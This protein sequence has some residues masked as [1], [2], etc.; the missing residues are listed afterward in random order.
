MLC[1]RC[2]KRQAV[3]H[4][5][6]NINGNKQE[7]HLCKECARE[8]KGIF[9]DESFP[10]NALLASLLNM[11]AEAPF[12]VEKLETVKCDKCGQTFGEFKATGRLGCSHCFYVYRDRLVP[13]LKRI[14][15]NTQHSGKIPRRMGGSLR[16]RKEI[17]QLRDQLEKAIRMEEYEKAAELR[18]KI[19]ALNGKL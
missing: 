15:G 13:L 17:S 5:I 3:V 2:G 11:G 19:K 7:V 4:R 18:D 12:K 1:D 8:E 9:I 14:H 6:I 16:V 10:I